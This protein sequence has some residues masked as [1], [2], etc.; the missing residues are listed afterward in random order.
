MV[1]FLTHIT[2]KTLVYNTAIVFNYARRQIGAAFMT[3][4]VPMLWTEHN[5]QLEAKYLTTA[6]MK[7][8]KGGTTLLRNNNNNANNCGNKKVRDPNTAD[9]ACTRFNNT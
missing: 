8:A 1:M 3:P 9:Y 2:E 5:Y 7:S 6:N 4:H